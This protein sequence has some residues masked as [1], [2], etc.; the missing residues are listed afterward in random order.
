MSVRLT[1]EQEK[2]Y[3]AILDRY[4]YHYDFFELYIK[5]Q[6]VCIHPVLLNIN[7]SHTFRIRDC[8]K[9]VY[10]FSKLKPII[11]IDETKLEA[12][13]DE[14]MS[15]DILTVGTERE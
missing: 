4:K 2:A 8:S 5:L 6:K 11:N 10:L 15:T 14:N 7:R 1:D 3:N 9:L 12:V 13:F